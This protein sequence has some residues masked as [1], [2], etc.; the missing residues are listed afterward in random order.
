M[1][2]STIAITVVRSK[3]PRIAESLIDVRLC[4]VA[5]PLQLDHDNTA[6]DKEDSIGAAALEGKAILQNRRI[7]WRASIALTNLADLLLESWN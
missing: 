2:G 6:G 4:R 3:I 7:G 1:C 5:L